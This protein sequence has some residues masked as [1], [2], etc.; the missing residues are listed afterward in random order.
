MF[1]R[2]KAGISIACAAAALALL[3]APV[4]AQ[5]G[6]P[7]AAFECS[8]P[9]NDARFGSAIDAEG[10]RALVGALGHNSAAARTGAAFVFERERGA[11]IER[12]A[13]IASDAGHGDEFGLAV[14]LEGDRALV[15]AHGWD[16]PTALDAGAA[17]VFER[18]AD[19]SWL[20]VA[21]LVA[22]TPT[23]FAHLGWSVALDGDRALVGAVSDGSAGALAGAA[24][25]FERQGDGSW[26]EVVKLTD[27]NAQFGD[28]FGHAVALVGDDALVTALHD[29]DAASSAGAVHV[30][31]RD[32]AGA[33]SHVQ[34]FT[35]GLGQA[36]AR[37]GQSICAEGATAVIG[38]ALSGQANN[39]P[40]RVYVFERDAAGAWSESAVLLGKVGSP[41][42]G[43][44]LDVDL[45]G[46]LLV[47][48][49]RRNA[50]ASSGTGMVRAFRRAD[51][52]AWTWLA[53]AASSAADT[54]DRF[55]SAVAVIDED[56]FLAGAWG[57]AVGGQATA[58]R[59][60]ATRVAA[61][62]QSAP[63]VSV[64]APAAIDLVL[65][66]GVERAGGLFVV[67]GSV[68]GTGPTAFEGIDVP[69]SF[70]AYTDHTVL[71][72]GYAPLLGNVGVLDA[73]GT[74][75][76]RFEL[77]AGL[78][79]AFA[80]LTVHHAAIVIVPPVYWPP[81]LVTEPIGLVLVP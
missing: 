38:T 26:L 12:T 22:A 50:F 71:A 69:L 25:V 70:D 52:G 4:W 5:V 11:W 27:P 49:S 81:S 32:P 17:Y 62:M 74:A 15:G 66:G 2:R 61:L 54:F 41:Y 21:K 13:L 73:Q 79:P 47:V 64:A 30:F 55:G 35:G 45:V 34:Q 6:G 28:S 20:E 29:D 43:F 1:S 58:G 42:F 76:A 59:V 39:D 65:F 57:T 63:T 80:G 53:D 24:L 33:W 19:G 56:E 18:Q 36:N 37:F 44:G 72:H 16:A 23:V 40:G 68:S 77:P 10:T 8:T 14:A 51:G 31:R 60:Y 46:D 48:G 67:A 7:D 75:T 9:T 3:P 78:S